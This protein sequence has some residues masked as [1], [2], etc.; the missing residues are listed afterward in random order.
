MILLNPILPNKNFEPGPNM[1][2]YPWALNKALFD[3]LN[4][5]TFKWININQVWNIIPN[6]KNI[7]FIRHLESMYNEYKRI[8]KKDS[9]YTKFQN[10]IDKEKKQELA[11]ILLKEFR[12]QVWLDFPTWISKIW[13]QQW[14]INW[15]L[16]AKLIANNSQLMPTLI[17]IS[18][19]FRTRLTA[20]YFLKYIKW[21]DLNIDKLIDPNNR[22]DMIIWKFMWREIKIKLNDRV[23][24]RD[25]GSDVAPS[26]LRD[27][28]ETLSPFS[29]KSFLS[30]DEW[31]I[32]YYYNAPTG[33]ESQVQVNDR[34]KLALESMSR[35][36]DQNIAVFS[37]HIAIL[38]VLN[39]I[40]AWAINTYFNLDK[41]W[42][43]DNASITV[44]SQIKKT[45]SGQKNRFRVSAYNLKLWE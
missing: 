26:Y 1:K 32:A 45:Q 10:T 39:N 23:R 34:I 17:I 7:L 2:L 24:E 20:H 3:A 37:H 41:N 18:P 8:I 30:E 38:A 33:W 11:I 19:Y 14:E 22:Q 4:K 15:K 27:Y 29:P 9:R 13:H 28:L 16:F 6:C 12:E 40:F 36:S 31:D 43:P 21:L 5:E 42:K 35:E 25:H 44:V